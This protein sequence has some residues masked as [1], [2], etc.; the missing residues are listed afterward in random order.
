MA[1]AL[2]RFRGLE[3]SL[4]H[5]QEDQI[6]RL[7]ARLLT[8]DMRGRQDQFPAVELSGRARGERPVLLLRATLGK[9]SNHERSYSGQHDL[10]GSDLLSRHIQYFINRLNRE[11]RV[12]RYSVYSIKDGGTAGTRNQRVTWPRINALDAKVLYFQT[13]FN[14]ASWTVAG[15]SPVSRS[16][17]YAPGPGDFTN[18][19]ALYTIFRSCCAAM[20]RGSHT[21]AKGGA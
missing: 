10:S 13:A 7:I 17:F 16:I 9:Y 14:F 12:R 4:G 6:G 1:A 18:S 5:G 8:Q 19:R 21:G 3:S 2:Q 15:S 11:R 20:S